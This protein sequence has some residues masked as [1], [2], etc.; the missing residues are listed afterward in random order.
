MS[1]LTLV[2]PLVLPAEGAVRV[3]VQLDGPEG[4]DGR[5]ALSIYSRA[6]D[7]PEE[8]SWTLHAQGVLSSA[9]EAAAADE[10]GLAAWPPAG[11]EPID[12]TGHYAALAARGYGYG[13][14]FQGLREA[15]RV[16]DAV[17][18]RVVLAE[19]LTS[20]ADEYGL[21]PALLD[22]A[23]HVLGLVDGGRGCR[24]GF[25]AAAVRVV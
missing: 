7:A 17:Y 12:L 13:P 1:Q 11:G 9:E 15:W 8:A 14:S 18:G 22:S 5:R 2:S 6:E 21:H 19:A 4:E 3:Q 20:S 23:L 25:A 24:R 10:T 16:G